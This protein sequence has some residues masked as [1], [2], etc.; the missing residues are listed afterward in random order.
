MRLRKACV[1]FKWHLSQPSEKALLHYLSMHWV[2]VVN[3]PQQK[4]K[5]ITFMKSQKRSHE[6]LAKRDYHLQDV[7]IF[8]QKSN[9]RF[10]YLQQQ[11]SRL[12]YFELDSFIK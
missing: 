10:K 2:A 6:H 4:T 12:L 9:M 5:L 11:I 7:L 3:T 1:D 8:K